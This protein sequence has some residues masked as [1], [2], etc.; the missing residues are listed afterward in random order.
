MIQGIPPTHQQNYEKRKKYM[1]IH[2]SLHGGDLASHGSIGKANFQ[3][4]RWALLRA[5][6]GVVATN[7]RAAAAETS[8]PLY[9]TPTG[10]APLSSQNTAERKLSQSTQ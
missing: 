2:V 8:D 4:T 5:S 7:S 1:F 3:A 9:K 10:A 6:S